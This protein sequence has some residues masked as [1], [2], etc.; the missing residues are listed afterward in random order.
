MTTDTITVAVDGNV[1]TVRR[2]APNF[3]GLRKALYEDNWAEVPALLTVAGSIE[4]WSKGDFRVVGGKVHLKGDA[5]PG[6]L[7][8]RIVTMV[9]KSEDPS[10]L[11]NFW[12]KLQRNPSHRSVSQLWAFL[13]H[14]NIPLTED[15][16]FLAYKSVRADY[17]DHHS[18]TVDNT[19]GVINEMPR[20]QISDDPNHACHEGYHVGALGYASRFGGGDRRIVICKVD[21]ADVVCVPYDSSQEKMRVCKYEVFGHYGSDLPDTVYPPDTDEYEE[22]DED[23]YEEDDEGEDFAPVPFGVPALKD[24]DPGPSPKAK[25]ADA[26]IK[27]SKRGSGWAAFDRMDEEKLLDQSLD[28]LRKY[29]SNGLRILGASKIPGGKMALVA[30]IMDVRE[31]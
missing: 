11:L 31:S 9:T 29:A 1:S 5:L 22:D 24:I 23:E 15:G 14:K 10:S 13:S 25:T 16:C 3:P 8:K 21:P 18:G 6:E 26:P 12:E 28:S 7:S 4:S 19:V 2:G 27:K 20:N 30:R 17:K